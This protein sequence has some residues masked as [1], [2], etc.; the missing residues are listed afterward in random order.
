MELI[1]ENGVLKK[2][3]W[4]GEDTIVVPEGVTSIDA[5]A[6]EDTFGG[7]RVVLPASLKFIDAEGFE[8]GG[9]ILEFTVSEQSPHFKTVDGNLYTKDGKSL[10]R[11]ASGKKEARFE[12]PKGLFDIAENAVAYAWNLE[13]II[14]PDGLWEIKDGAFSGCKKL[15]KIEIPLSV[16]SIGDYA[17]TFCEALTTI[18]I[19]ETVEFMGDNVFYYCQDLKKVFC[20]AEELPDDWSED[21]IGDK[22]DAEVIWGEMEE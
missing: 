13:E 3:D 2:I 12:V 18:S 1:I 7:L 8:D 14:L 20:E 5:F 15:K 6:F 22:C 17:F 16:T 9:D 10:I 21:F 19:P 4:D 11:Y